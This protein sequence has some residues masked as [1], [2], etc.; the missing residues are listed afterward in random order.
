[1]AEF[2]KWLSYTEHQLETICYCANTKIK[3]DW[4]DIVS[5]HKVSDSL[6]LLW[7]IVLNRCQDL[8]VF[9]N[10]NLQNCSIVKL[11]KS[12]IDTNIYV[13]RLCVIIRVQFVFMHLI[14]LWFIN[15]ISNN[16]KV[17]VTHC[18]M[19]PLLPFRPLCAIFTHF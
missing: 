13:F 11:F 9:K 1:L 10:H 6:L 18:Q 14:P 19:K 12:R 7:L 16:N 5:H 17:D 15:S 4:K 8:Y 3:S 2:V